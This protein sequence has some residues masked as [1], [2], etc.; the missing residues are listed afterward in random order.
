MFDHRRQSRLH[1]MPTQRISF[2]NP[3]GE[4]LAGLIDLPSGQVRAW[5]LFAHCF[6]C[7][8]NLKAAMHLSRALN[9]QGIAVMRFDFT[10]L[11]QSEGKFSDTNFSS[12]V[13]DLLAAVSYL[14]T[15]QTAPALLVGHSL[16]GTAVLAAAPH[17]PSAVAVATIGSPAQ[18]EHVRHLLGDSLMELDSAGSAEVNLGG[19]PFRVKRQMLEDLT[20]HDL[21]AELGG[22][23]KAVLFMHAPLDA[24][25]EIDNA[26]ALFMAARHPKSFLSLDDADHLLSREADSRYAGRVL[27]AWA[28]KYLPARPERE[29]PGAVA[30]ASVATTGRGSFTTEISASGH[31]L[32]VDEPL[33]VGGAN[34]GPSPYDLLS[35]AL[36]SCTSMTLN[37]YAARKGIALDSATVQVRHDKLHAQDCEDCESRAGKIDQFQREIILEGALSDAERQRLLEI[38]DRCPVHKT[39]HSEVKIR[40]GGSPGRE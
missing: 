27:A 8:K 31:P 19:R 13:Q 4:K 26:S 9:A 33:S 10:G 35:A 5:A 22:I 16:G 28:S 29:I 30:G 36:A 34:Q 39:L 23:R 2:S 21:L 37:M 11:G 14:E 32:T 20:R 7:S 1:L 18:P 3:E 6:T 24:T 40:T 25:V 12:N 38:A 15:H 17:V